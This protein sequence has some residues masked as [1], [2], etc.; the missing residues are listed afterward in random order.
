M[1]ALNI[2]RTSRPKPTRLPNITRRRWISNDTELIRAARN[3]LLN[4]DSSASA[5]ALESAAKYESIRKQKTVLPLKLNIEKYDQLSSLACELK[6][7]AENDP[8]TDMREIARTELG[9]ISEETMPTTITELKENL[10]KLISPRPMAYSQSALVEI[11]AGVGG[12]EAAHFATLLMSLYTR[13]ATRKRWQIKPVSVEHM[14]SGQ[15]QDGLREAVL[16]IEGPDVY[17]SLRW[18]AGVHRVQRIPFLQTTCAIHTSTASVIV[19][20]LSP[21]GSEKNVEENLFEE[22]DLRLE[23]MRAQGAGGQHVNKTESAV[24]LTHIPTGTVVMMQDSRSQH[25]NRER[26]YMILRARLLDLKLRQ[27]VIENRENRLSQ[28]KNSNR[29]E[30]IRTYNFPQGRVTDHRIGLTLPRLND[31]VE[32]GETIDI[33]WDGLE[34]DEETEILD[35]LISTTSISK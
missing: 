15:G 9:A 2:L 14:H 22:K 26:A 30:K 19:L 34:K 28:V 5:S 7:I 23:T 11:K 1:S 10:I 8:D 33:I 32:G 17:G 21:P 24:R 16:E 25:Q 3:Y 12:I 4:L 31:I 6:T 13:L 35:S 29:S 18:E 27:K 20:P